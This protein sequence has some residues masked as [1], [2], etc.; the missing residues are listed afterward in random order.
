MTI[1]A[2]QEIVHRLICPYTLEQNG[3][4]KRKNRH[5]VEMGIT[6]LT[7]AILSMNY[8]GYPFCYASQ[9]I[10]LQ[11]FYNSNIRFGH[12]MGVIPLTPIYGCSDVVV[13]L[14]YDHL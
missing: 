5:I 14:I 4:A 8:W 6:L 2:S 12:S 3:V 9:I 7:Q 1:L 10:F 13:S 11:Q